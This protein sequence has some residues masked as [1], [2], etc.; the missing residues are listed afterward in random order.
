MKKSIVIA[1]VLIGA[2]FTACNR[3]N[4]DPSIPACI[5]ERISQAEA[6]E[7]GIDFGYRMIAPVDLVSIYRYQHKGDQYFELVYHIADGFTELYDQNC[8]YVCSPNGGFWGGGAGDCEEW[9]DINDRELI[10]QRD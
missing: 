7:Q 9:V 6:G 4:I 8:E 2:S 3:Q 10:W 1:L 5:Q